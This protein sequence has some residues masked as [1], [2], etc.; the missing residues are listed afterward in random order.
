MLSLESHSVNY[1]VIACFSFDKCV[2]NTAN[3]C[4]VLS[5][6]RH[7]VDPALKRMPLRE[8]NTAAQK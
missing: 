5:S 1:K 2:V 4:I 8:I 3:L 6:M 7:N